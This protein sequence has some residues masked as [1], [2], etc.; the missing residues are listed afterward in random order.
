MGVNEQQFY[1]P[2]IANINALRRR[3]PRPWP[4]SPRHNLP[5]SDAGHPRSRRHSIR[6]ASKARIPAEARAIMQRSIDELRAS[7]IMERV[8]RVGQAAPDFTLPNANGESIHLG[9]LVARRPVVL[10]FYRGRW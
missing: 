7:G 5:D 2:R 4:R 6:E 10:S 8:A 3:C 9:D 1:L